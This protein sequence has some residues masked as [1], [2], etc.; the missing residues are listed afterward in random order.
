MIAQLEPFLDFNRDYIVQQYE[1]N[2]SLYEQTGQEPRPWSFGTHYLRQVCFW[3]VLIIL[4]GEIYRSMTGIYAYAG[5]AIRTPG[6]YT[7]MDP[8]TGSPTRKALRNTNEYI[9]PSVRSR[10]YLDGPGIEDRGLYSCRAMDEYKLR[11]T[12]SRP[13]DNRPIAVWES[14]AKRK[15]LPR[16]TL[17]ESPLWET[18]L[19]LLRYSQRVEEF[20]F[21]EQRN[22]RRRGMTGGR[23]TTRLS[24]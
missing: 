4:T 2:I 18:E 13:E 12:G 21:E 24:P 9:H 5:K 23:A 20:L 6:S 15:G 10:I 16:K 1:S 11:L 7:R 17:P 19:K 8:A 14:R 3:L 22:R